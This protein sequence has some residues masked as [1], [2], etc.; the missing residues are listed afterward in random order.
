MDTPQIVIKRVGP[1]P[2]RAPHDASII[3]IP[4]RI[5]VETPEG[6]A[7]LNLSPSAVPVLAVELEI[8]MKARGS[9]RV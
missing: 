6:P 3:T 5:E 9:H 2:G 4:F 1:V 8:W 7:V